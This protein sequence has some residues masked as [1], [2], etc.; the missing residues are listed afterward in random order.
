MGP[1]FHAGRYMWI[2]YMIGEV[3]VLLSVY[4]M[5]C[6]SGKGNDTLG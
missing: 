3:C 5:S 6:G 2:V 1:V 4:V